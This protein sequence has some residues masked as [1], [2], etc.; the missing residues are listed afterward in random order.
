MSDTERRIG[1]LIDC[2]NTSPKSAEHALRVVAQF[3]RAVRRG[4]GNH[5][6]LANK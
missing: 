4:Y 6:T 2:D 5:Q 3:G 1:V